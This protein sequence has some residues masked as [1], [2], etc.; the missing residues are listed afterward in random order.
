MPGLWISASYSSGTRKNHERYTYT[1]HR[2]TDKL[3]NGTLYAPRYEEALLPAGKKRPRSL[4]SLGLASLPVERKRRQR[5]LILAA[6]LVRSKE[7]KK[8]VTKEN[9]KKSAIPKTHNEI[10]SSPA[11][12]TTSRRRATRHV[13]RVSPYSPAFI[14]PGL[15]EIGLAQL[16]RSV[17]NTNFTQT[18]RQTDKTN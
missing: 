16:S 15:V 14:D 7:N 13:P 18:D 12:A 9:A 4:R 5:G 10:H 1:V 3:N 11:T 6:D 17:K 8:N 2:Q